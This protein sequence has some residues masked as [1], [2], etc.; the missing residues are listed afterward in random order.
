MYL[1]S[2]KSPTTRMS[3]CECLLMISSALFMS[4]FVCFRRGFIFFMFFEEYMGVIVSRARIDRIAHVLR[5]N[6]KKIVTTNGAFD[7]LHAG[8]VKVLQ[9][10]RGLGD[11]LIVGLNSDASVK[12]L[13]GKGRPIN[14]EKDRALVLAALG[15]VDFVVVFGEDTPNTLL[16]S[17]KPDIH[18]KAEDYEL[19][20]KS[21]A[22]KIWEREVVEKYG[23]K[24]VLLQLVKGKSTTGMIEKIVKAY[25]GAKQF[26]ECREM[27]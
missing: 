15:C 24:V 17:I 19:N 10:A 1:S 13:K 25:H 12:R 2:M 8:H 6:G 23:G 3:C 22:K 14:V 16:E 4:M 20:A 9:Q 26:K 18:V 27:K 11:V 21:P 7:L 5:K